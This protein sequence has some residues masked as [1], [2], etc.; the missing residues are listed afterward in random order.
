MIDT[1]RFQ[2][3]TGDE[4]VPL[5]DGWWFRQQVA[6]CT[7][8]LPADGQFDRDLRWG[9]PTQ[10]SLQTPDGAE[11]IHDDRLLSAALVVEAERHAQTGGWHTGQ[12]HSQIVRGSDPW[13]QS[14][15]R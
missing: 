14:P 8:T 13:K 5:S 15:T 1:G 2:Y 7:Y 9:V 3:W 10:A 11:L 4:D 12:A 6:A